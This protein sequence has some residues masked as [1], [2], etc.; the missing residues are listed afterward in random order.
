MY[1]TRMI[2]QFGEGEPR[3]L[4]VQHLERQLRLAKAR[5]AWAGAV[6]PMRRAKR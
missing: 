2:H 3:E 4:K 5:L 1:D 6:Q